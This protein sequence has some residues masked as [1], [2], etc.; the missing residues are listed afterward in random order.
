MQLAT[1]TVDRLGQVDRGFLLAPLT[2]H[3]PDHLGEDKA[4]DRLA[5]ACAN[6]RGTSVTALALAR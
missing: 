1:L 6:D 4:A 3:G 2:P 5:E